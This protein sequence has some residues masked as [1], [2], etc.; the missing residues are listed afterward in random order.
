MRPLQ[1]QFFPSAT[2]V[3][4]QPPIF[5]Q[6]L[7]SCLFLGF[8]RCLGQ[9]AAAVLSPVAAGPW[10]DLIR[11]WPWLAMHQ[12]AVRVLASTRSTCRV[13][14][15]QLS[16]SCPLSRAGTPTV[17]QFCLSDQHFRRSC[18]RWATSLAMRASFGC[19]LSRSASPL[20]WFVPP[21]TPS[22]AVQKDAG[23]CRY[24]TPAA[25]QGTLSG[26]RT[27][28]GHPLPWVTSCTALT[29]TPE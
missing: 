18:L 26:T 8:S 4:R 24:S 15:E 7:D 13:V 25:L 19:F 3:A 1:L 22:S 14:P 11:L 17:L 29:Q 5:H 12:R 27:R 23:S 21:A 10:L 16:P 28:L 6:R 20:G 2:Q 9:R